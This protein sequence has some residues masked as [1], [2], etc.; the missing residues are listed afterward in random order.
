MKK[1]DKSMMEYHIYSTCIEIVGID[2]VRADTKLVFASNYDIASSSRAILQ[3]CLFS[4]NVFYM[5]LFDHAYDNSPTYMVKMSTWTKAIIYCYGCGHNYGMI[6][7]NE[8][9][10][11]LHFYS[12]L[13]VL[14]TITVLNRICEN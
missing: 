4:R 8:N 3:L 2:C 6:I 14:D 1:Y 5:F 10:L 7:S 13:I 9:I 11:Y 12:S